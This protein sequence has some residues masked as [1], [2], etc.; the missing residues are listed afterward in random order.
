LLLG[1]LGEGRLTDAKGRL[2]DF[3]NAM[4]I[5]TSNLGVREAQALTD[6]PEEQEKIILQVVKE[7]LRPELLNRIDE[8]VCFHALA[9]EVLEQ[10]VSRNL[11]ELRQQLLDEHGI[12][13]EAEPAARIFLAKASCD[14]HYGARPVER[15]LQRLVLSP[16]ARLL[17][18]AEV[19]RGQAIIITFSAAEGLR[20]Q[21]GAVDKACALPMVL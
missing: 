1:V 18:A 8:V 7:A 2:C 19:V 14:P 17:I 9:Q 11:R 21:S 5:F 4:V 10:I 15:T 3:S 6:H 20:V 12:E 16:I 13:L